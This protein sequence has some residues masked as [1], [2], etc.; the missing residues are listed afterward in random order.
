MKYELIIHTDDAAELIGLLSGNA[1]PGKSK[2]EKPAKQ[3]EKE[4][5]DDPEDDDLVGGNDSND[6]DVTFE[7]LQEKVSAKAQAGKRDAVKKLLTKYGATKL[8][9]LDKDKY[10]E[11]DKA[12][13]KI[14]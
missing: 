2:N 9:E 10:E 3:K 4:P 8:T 12:I 11:F 6:D 14:K 5:E 1:A 7:T 13:D